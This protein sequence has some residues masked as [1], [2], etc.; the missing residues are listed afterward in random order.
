MWQRDCFGRK[1][2]HHKHGLK[3]E[4]T[5]DHIACRGR[6]KNTR[7]ASEHG[8]ASPPPRSP[9]ADPRPLW[10]STSR[11]RIDRDADSPV[12]EVGRRAPPG[13][14]LPGAGAPLPPPSPH[15]A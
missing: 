7:T 10:G 14:W 1:L 2:E 12:L 4:G 11:A 13:Q 8:E 3:T 9:S 6:G 5:G 15:L